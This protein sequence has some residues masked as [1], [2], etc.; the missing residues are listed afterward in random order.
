MD[1][2]AWKATA[3]GRTASPGRAY[4]GAMLGIAAIA[5]LSAPGTLEW[6]RRLPADPTSDRIVAAAEA[7]EALAE[8]TGL[9]RPWKAVRGLAGEWIWGSVG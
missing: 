1:G 5:L 2:N 8:E 3:G 7:M 4:A 9:D 6:A